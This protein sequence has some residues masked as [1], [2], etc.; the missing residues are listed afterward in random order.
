MTHSATP[1]SSPFS[2]SADGGANAGENSMPVIQKTNLK[3][4]NDGIPAMVDR[5]ANGAA[6]ADVDALLARIAQLEAQVASKSTLKCKV[7]D[8]G[9]VSV[10][11]LQ[12]FPITLYREQ[13][14]R[15]LAA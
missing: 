1:L 4:D 8:K 7:S 6:K 12:R 10:Y 13:F 11:G 9:G 14:E 2:N 5:R 15:L 3:A